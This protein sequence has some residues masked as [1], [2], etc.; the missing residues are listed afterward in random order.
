MMM[1]EGNKIDFN[2]TCKLIVITKEN[3]LF[4]LSS[5]IKMDFS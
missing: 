4:W 3:L 2:E 1:D 5:F